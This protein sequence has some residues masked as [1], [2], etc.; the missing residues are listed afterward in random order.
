MS[1]YIKPEDLI[2]EFLKLN[3]N[4]HVEKNYW[5]LIRY[6][7]TPSI[8]LYLPRFLQAPV[9]T[10]YDYEYVNRV[11]AVLKALKNLRDGVDIYISTR[12]TELPE[13]FHS[14]LPSLIVEPTD[15]NFSV[16]HRGEGVAKILLKEQ[17]PNILSNIWIHE[18]LLSKV[19]NLIWDLVSTTHKYY[20][21]S[22]GSE[23]AFRDVF[24]KGAI[25]L[26]LDYIKIESE[27]GVELGLRFLLP[28]EASEE[29]VKTEIIK[30]LK[31][32]ESVEVLDI[33]IIKL[34]ARVLPDREI[35]EIASKAF[36]EIFREPEYEWFPFAT[37]FNDLS[38]SN[39]SI[40]AVGPHSHI[41]I[42]TCDEKLLAQEKIKILEIFTSFISKVI[43]SLEKK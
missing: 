21:V 19:Q 9:L 22:R 37:V 4:V 12:N 30:R 26:G 15:M 11:L 25:V 14:N 43:S 20:P 16:V 24:L 40:L 2:L 23:I 27:D 3:P 28:P 13:A 36:A 7:E 29:V 6:G 17:T 39:T 35:H 38:R 33:R 1:N 8:A 31:S 41:N 18:D 5:H 10:C 32:P 34:P 42:T